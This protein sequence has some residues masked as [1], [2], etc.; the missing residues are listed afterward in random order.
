MVLCLALSYGGRD[1]IAD[2]CR[3]IA[4]AVQA[5]RIAVNDIDAT[6]VAAHLYAPHA[7]DVDL[8]VRTAAEQRLSNF[9]PWQTTYAEYVSLPVLWPDMAAADLHVALCEYQ[10]RERR[11]GAV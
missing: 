7:A 3:A 11:F 4:A 9:L 6:V 2:A 8:V 5:G 10:G 1:E